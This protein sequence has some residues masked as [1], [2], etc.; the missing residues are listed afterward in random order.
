MSLNLDATKWGFYLQ[1][2]KKFHPPWL[3]DNANV[4]R[5]SSQKYLG[6]ILDTHLKFDAI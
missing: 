6:I 3:F 1:I 4:R 2:K 5:T